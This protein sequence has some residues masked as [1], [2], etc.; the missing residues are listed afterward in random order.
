MNNKILAIKI[1]RKKIYAYVE[2][3]GWINIEQINSIYILNFLIERIK[4]S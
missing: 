1:K 2:N 3:N 4:S